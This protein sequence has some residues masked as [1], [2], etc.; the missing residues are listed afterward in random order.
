[1]R[2]VTVIRIFLS[3][4]LIYFIWQETGWAMAI[5]LI[6]LENECSMSTNDQIIKSLRL[7]T[8]LS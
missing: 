3:A 1:M 7:I 5:S 2:A 4:V 6:T 8:K